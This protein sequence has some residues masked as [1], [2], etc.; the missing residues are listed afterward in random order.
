[1]SSTS[2]LKTDDKQMSVLSDKL[3]WCYL[4][5][6]NT[7]NDSCIIEMGMLSDNN[8]VDNEI[9]LI[10]GITPIELKDQKGNIIGYTIKNHSMGPNKKWVNKNKTLEEKRI[11]AEKYL[12][13]LD[14]LTEPIT[15]LIK[16][17]LFQ[18]IIKRRKHGFS[19][20][21]KEDKN[22]YFIN[23]IL[24]VKQNYNNAFRFYNKEHL[25][26]EEEI[27]LNVADQFVDLESGSAFRSISTQTDNFLLAGY[28]QPKKTYIKKKKVSKYQPET[29]NTEKYKPKNTQVTI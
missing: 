23:K 9:T 6:N 7:D 11:K 28:N 21:N 3:S 14:S 29:K 18:G 27:D 25:N 5:E 22:V 4:S 19:V 16:F 12:E 10:N 24:S 8:N 2:E 13:K 1:M 26:I 15:P 20:R 17:N